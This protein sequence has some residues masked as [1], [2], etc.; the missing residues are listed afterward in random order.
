MIIVILWNKTNCLCSFIIL[1]HATF[2]LFICCMSI[3]LICTIP[4]MLSC[5]RIICNVCNVQFGYAI[6]DHVDKMYFTWG[7]FAGAMIWANKFIF[8]NL[9]ASRSPGQLFIKVWCLNNVLLYRRGWVIIK[10]MKHIYSLP[11]Y[12]I[13]FRIQFSGYSTF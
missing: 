5:W 8:L 3:Y 6:Y 10:I 7:P 2:I 12:L 4:G 1:M 9:V 13:N 11:F